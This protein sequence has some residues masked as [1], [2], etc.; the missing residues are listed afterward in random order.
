[1]GGQNP[2]MKFRVGAIH[3]AVWENDLVIKGKRMPVLRVTIGK[4]YKDR[5]GAWKMTGSFMREEIPS[6]IYCLQRAMESMMKEQSNSSSSVVNDEQ[7]M[8]EIPA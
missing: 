7:T 2:V 5:N 1:M 3:C 6:A 8:D 4:G